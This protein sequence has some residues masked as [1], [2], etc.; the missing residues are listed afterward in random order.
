MFVHVL[1]LG[2]IISMTGYNSKRTKKL[3]A[4]GE[5]GRAEKRNWALS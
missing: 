2:N 5:G 3:T 4:K 1:S